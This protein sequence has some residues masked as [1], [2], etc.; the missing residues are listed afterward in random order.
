M[1]TERAVWLETKE[2]ILAAKTS[3]IFPKTRSGLKELIRHIRKV[4]VENNLCDQA[5]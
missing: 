2:T 5:A 1:T 4:V 3:L